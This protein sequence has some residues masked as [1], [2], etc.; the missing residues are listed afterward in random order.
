MCTLLYILKEIS[1]IPITIING[2]ACLIR[3]YRRYLLLILFTIHITTESYLKRWVGMSHL[4]TIA[5]L[6]KYLSQNETFF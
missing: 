6:T 5:S 1:N 4:S 2:L 3:S